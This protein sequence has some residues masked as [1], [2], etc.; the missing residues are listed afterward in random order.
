VSVTK[1]NHGIQQAQ[2]QGI[3]GR[4]ISGR[5][6]LTRLRERRQEKNKNYM[7]KE[8]QSDLQKRQ[9][10]SGGSQLWKRRRAA[11][12]R[13][14]A[15]GLVPGSELE[16]EK[17]NNRVRQKRFNGVRKTTCLGSFRAW[18]KTM[19]GSA[20]GGGTLQTS[21]GVKRRPGRHQPGSTL[22]PGAVWTPNL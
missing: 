7:P 2:L 17:G 21:N 15:G 5:P 10:R 1:Q 16:G 3:G 22:Q 9:Q 4:N 20:V 6:S 11:F 19:I 14:A 8:I 12:E 18:G 13:S